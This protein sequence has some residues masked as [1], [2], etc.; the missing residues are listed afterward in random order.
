M[1]SLEL[2]RLARKLKNGT[3]LSISEQRALLD[4]VQ[5]A[6]ELGTV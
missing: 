6:A 3:S 5:E 2:R 4:T 1:K